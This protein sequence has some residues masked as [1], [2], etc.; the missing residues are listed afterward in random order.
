MYIKRAEISYSVEL[1]DQSL[2]RSVKFNSFIDEDVRF[3][4]KQRVTFLVVTS[5]AQV[6]F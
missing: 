6:P 3:I 2:M 4:F 5:V 1:L